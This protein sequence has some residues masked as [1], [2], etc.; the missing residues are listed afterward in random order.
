M[1][2]TAS[3]I[4]FLL[5]ALC[6]VLLASCSTRELS[7][8]DQK[9]VKRGDMSVLVTTNPTITGRI[10]RKATLDIIGDSPF[11]IRQVTIDILSID[12]QTV[13]QAWYHAN[14]EIA[15]EPGRHVI[16]AEYSLETQSTLSPE[17]REGTLSI[18]YVFEGGQKYEI[19]LEE[20]LNHFEI[21]IKPF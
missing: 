17:P 19:Y 2:N 11:D 12:G 21:G 13:D 5:T 4:R 20:Y 10:L 7:D 18:D 15:L 16:E 1:T 9:R 6:L 14:E 3:F 8:S